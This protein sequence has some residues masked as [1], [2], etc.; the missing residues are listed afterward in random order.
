MNKIFATV[1]ALALTALA[2][3]AAN[4]AFVVLP[5]NLDPAA[6]DSGIYGGSV[7]PLTANANTVFSG[8]TTFNIVN[9][10]GVINVGASNSITEAGTGT[11]S[12]FS[13]TI[14]DA[15]NN[16]IAT[17]GFGNNSSLPSNAFTAIGAYTLTVAYTYANVNS[18]S[19]A[20]SVTVTTAPV[21]TP[22]P[23]SLA[24]LGLGLVVLGAA[25]RRKV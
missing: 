10:N 13:Y 23:G 8:S 15:A 17:G 4:A 5:G 1:A 22:E 7:T 9:V 3:V 2:P 12:T 11:F 20:W 16:V 25:R 18:S 6:G 21:P 14:K 24:L 19:V